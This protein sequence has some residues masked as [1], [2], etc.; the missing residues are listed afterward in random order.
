MHKLSKPDKLL[1][2]Y[3]GKFH[4]RKTSGYRRN[5]YFMYIN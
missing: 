4:H 5:V 2:L 1:I 3:P